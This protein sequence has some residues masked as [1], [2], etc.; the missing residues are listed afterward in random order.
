MSCNSTFG[1]NSL[2]GN[3]FTTSSPNTPAAPFNSVQFNDSGDFGGDS[4]FT[5][6][7]NTLELTVTSI[8]P[9]TIK[10]VTNSVGT[11]GQ[12]LTSTGSGIDWATPLVGGAN[13]NIQFNNSGTLGGTANMT[14]NST[15]TNVN[16]LGNVGIGSS[17][18]PTDRLV[19]TGANSTIRV[20]STTTNNGYIVIEDASS[21][22]KQLAMQVNIDT[23]DFTSIQQGVAF[24]NFRFN[25]TADTACIGIGTTGAQ[26]LGGIMCSNFLSNRK[27]ILYSLANDEHQNYSLGVNAGTFRFQVPDSLP[28]T[29]YAWFAA[30]GSGASTELMRLTATGRLGIG[31]TSPAFPL[32]VN[33]TVSCTTLVSS[34]R[35]V[36][37]LIQDG[38]GTP[39]TGVAGQYLS[40]TGT[41]ILWTN[42]PLPYAFSGANNGPFI[43]TVPVPTT[44]PTVGFTL[45]RGGVY[46]VTVNIVVFPTAANS[47]VS[48]EVYTRQTAGGSWTIFSS[49]TSFMNNINIHLPFPSRS[50]Y[51]F[52]SAGLFEVCIRTGA[53]TGSNI[54]DPVSIDIL[55][56]SN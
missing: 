41:G 9:T 35:V 39:S 38:A 28:T 51:P 36:P 45:S 11:A 26:A 5:F 13:G 56:C 40:S 27:V 17:N 21:G 16:L 29:R 1:Y 14:Y 6:D 46:Q 43:T 18:T 7:P 24:R 55:E 49:Y 31:T 25:P 20:K 22:V 53:N 48:Y 10:D 54:S 4:S 34:D 37:G 23:A 8:K 15:T 47:N 50:F 44:L 2:V 30:T 19:V 52:L 3:C 33:G 42:R 32:Q 12:Y